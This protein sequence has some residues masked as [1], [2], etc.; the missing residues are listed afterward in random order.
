MTNHL[1]MSV[2]TIP[3]LN[4]VDTPHGFQRLPITFSHNVNP[5]LV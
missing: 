1:V 2:T 4:H 5:C 3:Q